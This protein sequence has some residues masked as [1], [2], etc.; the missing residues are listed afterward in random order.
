MGLPEAICSLVNDNQLKYAAFDDTATMKPTDGDMQI[1]HANKAFSTHG[2]VLRCR[3]S[4]F[5]LNK[6]G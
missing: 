5:L 2:L 6:D 4:D 1:M 3:N